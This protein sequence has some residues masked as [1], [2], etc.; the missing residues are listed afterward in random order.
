MFDKNEYLKHKRTDSVLS[1]N[2]TILCKI[3][4]G[5]RQKI[6]NHHKIMD[7]YILRLKFFLG[8]Q[9]DEA[10][11]KNTKALISCQ[12][13]KSTIE[14]LPIPN[15]GKLENCYIFDGGYFT[16]YE[17]AYSFGEVCLP[18]SKCHTRVTSKG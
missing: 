4:D 10:R 7:N 13:H 14:I 1:E 3:E 17:I 6:D 5:L 8:K 16:E 15:T 11:V 2:I 18:M 9:T 12:R